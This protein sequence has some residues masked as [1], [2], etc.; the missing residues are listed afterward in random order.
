[1]QNLLFC[2]LTAL[3]LTISLNHMRMIQYNTVYSLLTPFAYPFVHPRE[4]HQT[5][6]NCTQFRPAMAPK[7]WKRY[8]LESQSPSLSSWSTHEFP[9]INTH[10]WVEWGRHNADGIRRMCTVHFETCQKCLKDVPLARF[11][12]AERCLD[13]FLHEDVSYKLRWGII[14][15]GPISSDWCK[16]LKEIWRQRRFF[17]RFLKVLIQSYTH[18]ILIIESNVMQGTIWAHSRCKIATNPRQKRSLV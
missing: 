11:Q 6:N 9:T 7:Q 18:H 15:C 13:G 1:M 3:V 4:R 12:S 14:G 2:G 10:I 16:C 5:C 17:C 8:L